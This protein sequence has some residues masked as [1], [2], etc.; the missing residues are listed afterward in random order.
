MEGKGD[1]IT[2][3]ELK[4]WGINLIKAKHVTKKENRANGQIMGH[5]FFPEK[6]KSS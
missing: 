4:H 1:K 5:F 3:E 2:C 6:T